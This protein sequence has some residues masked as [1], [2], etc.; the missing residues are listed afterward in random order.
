VSVTLVGAGPGDPGLI[1]VRGLERLR[2]CDAVVYDRLVSEELVDEA[3]ADA[4]RICRD[5]LTQEQVDRLLVELGRDLDVVRLKGGDPF[6]FGRGSEELE[7]LCDA[8][9][10]Y[11]VVPG[12]SSIAAVPGAAWIPVTHRGLSDRVTIATAHAADGSEPDYEALART[13]GTLVLFMGLARLPALAAGLIDAGLPADTPAA[14]VSR[15]TLPEQE[16]VSGPLAE[17]PAL[18]ADLPG[19]ALVVV[20]E[21]VALAAS[22]APLATLSA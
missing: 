20:G 7:V 16:V 3:P 21:V 13:G 9:I 11:D 19:P 22:L 15:G 17:L 5:G 10:A 4:L 1:T 18:A 12:I 6:V 14:V 2:A 8:G